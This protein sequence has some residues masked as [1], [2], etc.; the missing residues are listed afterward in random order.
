MTEQVR[1]INPNKVDPVLGVSKAAAARIRAREALA[2]AGIKSRTLW[3]GIDELADQRDDAERALA[4]VRALHKPK[5]YK[6]KTWDGGTEELTECEECIE[7]G[8][9]SN[10]SWPCDTIR[11]IEGEA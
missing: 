6:R 8:S 9:I 1:A 10:V 7:Y 5:T 11:A 2:D 4:R 3:E